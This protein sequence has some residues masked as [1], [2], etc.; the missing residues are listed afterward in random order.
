MAVLQVTETW[1]RQFT[2]EEWASQRHYDLSHYNDKTES[3]LVCGETFDR[4][5]GCARAKI[6]RDPDPR[7]DPDTAPILLVGPWERAFGVPVVLEQKT[8]ILWKRLYLLASW[9]DSSDFGRVYETTAEVK[10]KT[11]FMGEILRQTW[12]KSG[13][14]VHYIRGQ[15]PSFFSTA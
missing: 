11:L 15:R 10:K 8:T 7:Y 4:R 3:L 12:A 5:L 13:T 6:E 14:F 2:D 9:K 1:L